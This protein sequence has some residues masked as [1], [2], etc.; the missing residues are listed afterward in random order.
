MPNLELLLRKLREDTHGHQSTPEMERLADAEVALQQTMTSDQW[1]DFRVRAKDCTRRKLFTDR[2]ANFDVHWGRRWIC[3]R[4][5]ELGWTSKRF[6]NFDNH[7]GGY[8]QSF[9]GLERIGKKYQWLALHEL[10]ARMADN[11]VFLGG[12]WEEYDE[13]PPMY[14]GAREV[15]LRDIDPSLLTSKTHY[16]GWAEWGKTWW[17]P[18]DPQLRTMGSHERLAWLESEGDIINDSTLIDLCNPKTGRRWLA[19]SG[20]SKWNGFGVRDGRKKIQRDMW[21]RLTCIV[22]HRNNQAKMVKS[23]R[24]E[25]LTSPSSFPEFGLHSRYFYLGE[26]SW[27][28]EIG[29]FDQW[30]SHD[31]WQAFAVPI[32]PTVASYVCESGGYDRSVDQTIK[33]E[34]PAPW[35]AEEMGLR[36]SSGRSL[37]F[38]NSDGRDIFYDPSVAVAGPAAALVDRDAFLRMLDRQNLSAIWVIAGEK[39]AYDGR[40]GGMGFGGRLLHTTIYHL[41]GDGFSRHLYTDRIH[42]TADQL[43]EF[44]GEDPVPPGIETRPSD[45]QA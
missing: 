17:V 38:V 40:L 7:C 29:E 43:E 22:V 44:F 41:D 21:F 36:L 18:F 5:H 24:N 31:D 34:M 6:G 12:L 2:D 26:Y 3:K 8:G 19:L 37:A 42:P 33:V 15:G 23:L 28:P 14:R 30:S 35:L 45:P 4:A 1:E 10:I 39:S 16:D 27:H 20:F 9:P 13:E 11:L 25:I 32:R